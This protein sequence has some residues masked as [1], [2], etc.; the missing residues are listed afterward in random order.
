MQGKAF[1]K[2][3]NLSKQNF[4]KQMLLPLFSRYLEDKNMNNKEATRILWL[5]NKLSDAVLCV[6]LK[7]WQ[8]FCVEFNP[9]CWSVCAERVHGG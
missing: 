2:L 7:Q 4:Q 9:F 6:I 3:V 1:I 5:V 8:F